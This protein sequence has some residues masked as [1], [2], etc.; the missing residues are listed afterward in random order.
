MV[1]INQFPL[2][3]SN[4]GALIAEKCCSLVVLGLS[5]IIKL[6]R[7]KLSILSF[8]KLSIYQITNRYFFDKKFNL[9]QDYANIYAP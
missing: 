6:I 9:S 1:S 8:K 4:L 3:L 7:G 2:I 5:F